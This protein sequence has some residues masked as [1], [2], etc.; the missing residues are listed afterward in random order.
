MPRQVE[1]GNARLERGGAEGGHG[2]FVARGDHDRGL[3]VGLRQGLR[4]RNNIGGALAQQLCALKVAADH[5]LGRAR[6]FVSAQV[7]HD[8]H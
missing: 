2:H 5:V 6:Q 8:P 1:F 4:Q 3:R 7:Q